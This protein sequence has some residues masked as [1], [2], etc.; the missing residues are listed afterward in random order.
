MSLGHFGLDDLRV[1]DYVATKRETLAHFDGGI[2]VRLKEGAV[3]RYV[4]DIS[5]GYFGTIL[6]SFS[7]N[8]YWVSL[9]DL[10]KVDVLDALAELGK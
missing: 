8:N 3:G 4:Q 6:V 5:G 1:G 7:G 2:A 10:R 9:K